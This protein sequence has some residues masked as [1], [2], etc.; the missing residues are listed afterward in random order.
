MS[1]FSD[2]NNKLY[3]DA[4]TA[5]YDDS[6]TLSLLA[7]DKTKTIIVSSYDKVKDGI[8]YLDKKYHEDSS[9]NE[10][11]SDSNNE[12]SSDNEDYFNSSNQSN[13]DTDEYIFK[14]EPSKP[15]ILIKLKPY[16]TKIWVIDEEGNKRSVKGKISSYPYVNNIINQW[17]EYKQIVDQKQI[18][19]FNPSNRW[20]PSTEMLTTYRFSDSNRLNPLNIVI[21]KHDG[22]KY[23]PYPYLN[24]H[25]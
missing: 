15:N 5:L 1:W 14:M 24:T 22:I 20:Y 21:F 8:N 13:Q 6:K 12:D 10:D 2:K 25:L 18:N 19:N 3:K 16:I 9:N 23:K 7:L 4:L 17:F 11:S